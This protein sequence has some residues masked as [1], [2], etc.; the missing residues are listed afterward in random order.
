MIDWLFKFLILVCFI[1]FALDST[2]SPFD[3]SKPQYTAIAFLQSEFAPGLRRTDPWRIGSTPSYI[4]LQLSGA[5]CAS[6][7]LAISITFPSDLCSSIAIRH[8]ALGPLANLSH[9]TLQLCGP[10]Y[11][12]SRW[13]HHLFWSY[14][15][16]TWRRFAPQRSKLHQNV[17]LWAWCDS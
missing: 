9:S 15:L 17:Y 10:W 11:R 16:S 5:F 7:Y 2:G 12:S 1:S 14:R 3:F 6:V 13:H 8:R 4:F